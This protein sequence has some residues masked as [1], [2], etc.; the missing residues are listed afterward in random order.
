MS[1]KHYCPVCQEFL[2]RED[3]IEVECDYCENIIFIT[4]KPSRVN[5][6]KLEGLYSS[7][8]SNIKYL[9]FAFM[10]AIFAFEINLYFFLGF[11]IIYLASMSL[12]YSGI[13]FLIGLKYKYIHLIGEVDHKVVKIKDSP[14]FYYLLFAT[15]ILGITFSLIL[16]YNYCTWF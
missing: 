13:N 10:A 3:N 2:T 9:V 11:V 7:E 5:Y 1:S 6:T 15:N 16:F 12:Y 8:K 4:N 14:L